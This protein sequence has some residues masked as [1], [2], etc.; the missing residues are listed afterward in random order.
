MKCLSV[1]QP[2]A[3]LIL[4]GVKDVENRSWATAYRGPLLI[5]APLTMRAGALEYVRRWHDI[6]LDP[7]VLRFGVILGAVDLV[8]CRKKKTSRW[9]RRGD[10]GWY[11]ENVRR[12]RTPIAFKGQLKLFDVPDR[13]LPKSWRRGDAVAPDFSPTA[14]ERG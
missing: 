1:R 9:H 10:F 13:I 4:N 8:D 14:M 2:W 6:D 7:S 12:L 11:F 5:H 3:H